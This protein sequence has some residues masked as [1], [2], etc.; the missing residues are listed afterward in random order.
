MVERRN[1]RNT[2]GSTNSIGDHFERK[3]DIRLKRTI[4]K[5][6][7]LIDFSIKYMDLFGK[8]FVGGN[9]GCNHAGRVELVYN[10]GETKS[11]SSY[12]YDKRDLEDTEEQRFIESV[13]SIEKVQRDD[14][15]IPNSEQIM[16]GIGG[17][18][19][20]V[21]L[22][23]EREFGMLVQEEYGS[24]YREGQLVIITQEGP[25]PLFSELKTIAE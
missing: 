25:K 18:P 12:E 5:K 8:S 17:E 23:D 24:I 9:H 20:K 10:C 16:C 3:Y 4:E 11:W 2:W 15:F 13:A 7:W 6:P 14:I 21:K 1:N 22:D 19:Y